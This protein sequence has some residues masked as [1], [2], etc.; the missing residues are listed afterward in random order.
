M[1]TSSEYHEYIGGL[2][3]VKIQLLLMS[4]HYFG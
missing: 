3:Q 4:F 1:G 2:P